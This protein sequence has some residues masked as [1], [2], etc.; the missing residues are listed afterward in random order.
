MHFATHL[1]AFPKIFRISKNLEN[2]DGSMVFIVFPSR[3]AFLFTCV[4]RLF[5][6]LALGPLFLMFSTPFLLHFGSPFELETLFGEA[7]LGQFVHR[8]LRPFLKGFGSKKML[9]SFVRL[10]PF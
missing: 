8:F 3:K 10:V 4:F 5:F 1:F 6:A 2:N 9:Q 7:F